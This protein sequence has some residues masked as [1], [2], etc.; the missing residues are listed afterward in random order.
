MALSLIFVIKLHF[1]VL[2]ALGIMYKFQY[3]NFRLL[4]FGAMQLRVCVRVRARAYAKVS[5]ETT[6][7]IFRV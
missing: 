4:G 7:S 2:L 6:A 3:E 5:W 1:A